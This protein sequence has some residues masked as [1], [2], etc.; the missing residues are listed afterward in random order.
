[1]PSEMAIGVKC[2][3]ILKKIGIQAL[4]VNFGKGLA[5]MC[6]VGYST[7][8]EQVCYRLDGILPV[9]LHSASHFFQ[10]SQIIHGY[11]SQMK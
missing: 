3:E 11:P 10:F 1:M 9:T 4:Q 2:Y 7:L 5:V 8:Y 6:G